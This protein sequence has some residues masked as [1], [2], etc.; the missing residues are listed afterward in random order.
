M[1]IFKTSLCIS[2]ASLSASWTEILSAECFLNVSFFWLIC[3]AKGKF[4]LSERYGNWILSNW[5]IIM[6][7]QIQKKHFLYWNSFFVV[8][9]MKNV[10]SWVNT[11][12]SWPFI[13]YNRL[14]ADEAMWKRKN[15]AILESRFQFR[16][17]I[18][19]Y[20]L[21]ANQP[22]GKIP[23]MIKSWLLLNFNHSSTSTVGIVVV[24]MSFRRI[25]QFTK[26]NFA[27][28][29]TTKIIKFFHSPNHSLRNEHEWI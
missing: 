29:F 24:H 10:T 17:K 4:L 9:I 19:T 6:N 3:E 18:M 26:S 21:N 20:D 27:F 23:F 15:K 12:D 2:L 16:E 22:L 11:V 8:F 7:M 1:L 28:R 14:Y 25:Y 13:W 5:I